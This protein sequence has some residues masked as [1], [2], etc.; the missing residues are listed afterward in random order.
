MAA[1]RAE[2]SVMHGVGQVVG[3]ILWELP[4]AVLDGTMTGPPVVGTAMGVLGGTVRALQRTAAG[5][6]EIASAFDPWSIK[7]KPAE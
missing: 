6:V 4:K 5:L 7:R 2:P 1:E 3:G